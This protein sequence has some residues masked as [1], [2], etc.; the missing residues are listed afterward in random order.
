[1]QATKLT[2]RLPFSLLENAKSYAAA[3]NTTLTHLIGEYLR[4]IPARD[5]LLDQAPIVKR[6]TG[7]LSAQWTPEDY[8][9][10]L[11]EKYG[12]AG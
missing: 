6:L 5:E 12:R 2:I 9:K 8:K 7:T 1:M 11:E 3:H 4:R 10:H